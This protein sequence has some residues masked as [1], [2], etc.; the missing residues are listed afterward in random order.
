M[1]DEE[2]QEREDQETLEEAALSVTQRLQDRGKELMEDVS[3]EEDQANAT[4]DIIAAIR[5]LSN[6]EMCLAPFLQSRLLRAAACKTFEA[7]EHD[8]ISNLRMH[9][10]NLEGLLWCLLSSAP[11]LDRLNFLWEQ[12]TF[13]ME[14]V[15][16]QHRALGMRASTTLMSFA[17]LLLP[18]FE[19]ET[20]E[21]QTRCWASAN[22]S[23]AWSSATGTWRELERCWERSCPRNKRDRS[24]SGPFWQFSMGG[25]TSRELHWFSSTPS[26]GISAS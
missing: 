3:R 10:G 4:P 9:I 25:C 14:A 15:D 7:V 23:G 6:R 8:D 24:C 19:A 13:W 18:Q 26:W 5:C 1:Q 11:S 20:C 16:A 22:W 12:F 2:D 21:G 17:A